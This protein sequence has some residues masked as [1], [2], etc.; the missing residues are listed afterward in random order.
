MYYVPSKARP[1]TCPFP[2]LLPVPSFLKNNAGKSGDMADY[3]WSN[4]RERCLLQGK[5]IVDDYRGQV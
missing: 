4:Y 2:Q 1:S 5:F 3:K